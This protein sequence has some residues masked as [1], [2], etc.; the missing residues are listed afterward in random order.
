MDEDS[1]AARDG[2]VTAEDDAAP[3]DCIGARRGDPSLVFDFEYNLK[4]RNELRIVSTPIG[5]LPARNNRKDLSG[6]PFL[7]TAVQ[8]ELAEEAHSSRM[9]DTAPPSPPS[10]GSGHP[11]RDVAALLDATCARHN[12]EPRELVYRDLWARGLYVTPALQYGADF[13]AYRDDPSRCHSCA[14]V[15]VLDE[16]AQ[17]PVTRVVA[18]VRVAEANRKQVRES[19]PRNHP[20][21][22]ERLNGDVGE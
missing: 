10:S 5:T 18:A 16:A 20:Y 4:L 7:L 14:T 21:V 12:F 2:A 9:R 15:T 13:A 3:P 17:I 8:T 22:S 1:A 11:S 6:A 19:T